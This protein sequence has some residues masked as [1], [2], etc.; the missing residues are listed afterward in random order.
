MKRLHLSA[1]LIACTLQETLHCEYMDSKVFLEWTDYTHILISTLTGQQPAPATVAPWMPAPA[2]APTPTPRPA[3]ST[4]DT[5]M[6]TG[7][8]AAASNADHMS[9]NRSKV[10]SL[11]ANH[12]LVEPQ[13]KNN[14]GPLNS[15]KYIS[16]NHFCSL[17]R[18]A[19]LVCLNNV[20]KN[21]LG[22]CFCDMG[23]GVGTAEFFQVGGSIFMWN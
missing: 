3:P 16:L 12:A 15:A 6:M 17:N 14:L 18:T 11:S 20:A 4:Q 19:G 2:P 8:L 21:C 23:R 9:L 13:D 5:T 1:T 22:A 10:R 7:Q